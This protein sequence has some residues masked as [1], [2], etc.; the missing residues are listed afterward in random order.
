MLGTLEVQCSDFQFAGFVQLWLHSL[1]S[2]IPRTCSTSPGS[3]RGEDQYQTHS[4]WL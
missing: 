1:E 2:L 4:W 3:S